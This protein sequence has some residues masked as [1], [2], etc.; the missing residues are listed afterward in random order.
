MFVK[1][2]SKYIMKCYE[3][4]KGQIIDNYVV[5]LQRESAY[6]QLSRACHSVSTTNK[7]KASM[8]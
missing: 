1:G 3:S 8:K 2:S 4:S 7:I 5:T 6:H